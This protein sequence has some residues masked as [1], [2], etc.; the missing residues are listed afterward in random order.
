M[1]DT[2]RGTV[3]RGGPV[4]RGR[5]R[6]RRRAA[7]VTTDDDTPTP[8][9]GETQVPIQQT[10]PRQMDRAAILE[11]LREFLGESQSAAPGA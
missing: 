9:G 1:V 10:T 11:V 2:R 7:T 8:E 5:G 3:G 6:P 4:R